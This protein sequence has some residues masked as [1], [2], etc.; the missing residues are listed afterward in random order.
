[1]HFACL[2]LGFTVVSVTT[3]LL[4]SA[5]KMRIRLYMLEEIYNA[6]E[7]QHAPRACNKQC[8]SVVLPSCSCEV[9]LSSS[10]DMRLEIVP[11]MG[12]PCVRELALYYRKH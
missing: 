6:V 4:P 5:T 11:V 7:V 8:L 1:M 2:L 12:M 9:A 10:R 3:L